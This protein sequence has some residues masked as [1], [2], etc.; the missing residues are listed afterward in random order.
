M[1]NEST[2]KGEDALPTHELLLAARQRLNCRRP[3][4]IGSIHSIPFHAKLRARTLMPLYGGSSGPPSPSPETKTRRR[5][6]RRRLH[7]PL[8]T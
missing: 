7:T 5:R 2:A 1:S 8:A 3:E 6:H 4:R